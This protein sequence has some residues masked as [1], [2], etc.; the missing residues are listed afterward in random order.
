MFFF[1]FWQNSFT[2]Y[3]YEDYEIC[4][5]KAQKKK[6]AKKKMK[7]WRNHWW[8][9][10]NNSWTVQFFLFEGRGILNPLFASSSQR[11]PKCIWPKMFSIAPG[12]YDPIR[13][14]QSSTHMNINWKGQN[15][16]EHICFYFANWGP[17]QRDKKIQQKPLSWE[18]SHGPKRCFYY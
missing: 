10:K 11:V 9:I 18:P 12:F 1:F 17:K 16:E 14:A 5:G 15:L 13:F 8:E 7:K 2:T 4:H 3:K 6:S